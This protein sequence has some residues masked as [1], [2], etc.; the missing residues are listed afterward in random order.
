MCPFYSI[1]LT[2]DVTFSFAW[3]WWANSPILKNKPRFCCSTSGILHCLKWT[4]LWTLENIVKDYVWQTFA[5]K[6]E[7]VSFHVR[8]AVIFICSCPTSQ[9]LLKRG[10]Q[11]AVERGLWVIAKV[12]NDPLTSVLTLPEKIGGRLDGAFRFIKTSSPTLRYRAGPLRR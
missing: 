7:K 3:I 9:A 5:K 8:A 2:D 10:I 6:N 1:C 11:E 12:K 4:S